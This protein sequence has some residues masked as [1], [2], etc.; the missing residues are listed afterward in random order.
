MFIAFASF[1]VFVLARWPAHPDAPSRAP[2]GHHHH[3]QAPPWSL[4]SSWL[5]GGAAAGHQTGLGVP[6]AAAESMVLSDL[7]SEV[8]AL[9]EELREMRRHTAQRSAGD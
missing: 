9:R 7:L 5:L 1:V 2:P 3:H 4:S 6:V 8:R